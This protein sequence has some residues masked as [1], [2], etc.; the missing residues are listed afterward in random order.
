[1]K[2]IL[3]FKAS[4]LM[5][6]ALAVS[7]SLMSESYVPS[8]DYYKETIKSE[9]MLPSKGDVFAE[10]KAS[11]LPTLRYNPNDNNDLDLGAVNAPI[12]SYWMPLILFVGAYIV[13][14]CV[15]RSKLKSRTFDRS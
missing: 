14:K 1:M 11:E 5:L 2:K 6:L 8:N 15:S 13:G 10:A 4:I 12:G 9:S 7:T 3:N